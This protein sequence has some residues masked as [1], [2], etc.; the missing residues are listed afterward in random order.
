M[1]SLSTGR[2]R[3]AVFMDLANQSFSRELV[4]VK[5]F[6]FSFWSSMRGSCGSLRVNG[7]EVVERMPFNRN[8]MRPEDREIMTL[9]EAA[10][11]LRLSV[12]TMHQRKDIPRHRVPR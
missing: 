9:A 1:P 10:E 5:R 8:S 12:S 7:Y 4:T 11:F 6:A 2:P 3:T